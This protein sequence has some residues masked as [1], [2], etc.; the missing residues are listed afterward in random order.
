MVVVY[1][2]HLFL[3][4]MARRLSVARAAQAQLA[5]TPAPP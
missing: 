2:H 4:M 1:G 3:P 5:A